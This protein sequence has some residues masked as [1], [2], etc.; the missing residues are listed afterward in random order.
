MVH[1]AGAHTLRYRATDKAGNTA[2]EKTVDFTVVAPPAEDTTPPETVRRRSTGEK[3]SD[4]DFVN[5][6]TVTVTATDDGS[7]VAK[8]EYALDGGP[9][10]AYTAPVVVDRTGRHTVAHRA[11]DKAGNTSE[12][13]T[14]SFTV[15]EG[16]GVPA[17]DCAEWD[18]RLTVIIGTRQHRHPQPHHPQPLHHQRADRGREGLVLAG[19]LPQARPRCHRRS[20]HGR[21]RRRPG[22]QGPQQGRPAV[23]HR[24]PGAAHRLPRPLRRDAEVLRRVGARRRRRLRPQRRRHHDQQLHR[25]RAWACCGT[26]GAPTTTSPSSSSSATTRP[27]PATPT[28][29]CSSASPTSTTTPRS[30]AP[31]GS[32]SNTGTRSRSS[33]APTAT[34]TRPDPS[35]ASTAWA[36]AAPGSPP[37]APGTTTR[38]ASSTSTTAI[39]RN[40]V[41]L[42][43]FDNTGGQVFN[44]PRDDDPGT[45]G[46]RYASGYLGL[47]VHSETDVISYRNIRIQ[48]L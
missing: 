19:P 37:R 36:S 30:P 3:N 5:R 24:H 18:E 11:T 46:R 47:Q 16:G 21:G 1:D 6:A 20:A 12:A 32:P 34:C 17:P 10:L 38:S 28:A 23:R 29:A 26:P 13:R 39:Y 33:T 44:P 31:S 45:D 27:A 15:A 9:Y 8:T 35:T 41:L 7:G 25:R 2:P 40:G 43:E 14:V 48:E 42:N 4:G 22:V